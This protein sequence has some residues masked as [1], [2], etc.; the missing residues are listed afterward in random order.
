MSVPHLEEK[1]RR[2]IYLLPNAFTTANL[3]AGFYAVVQAMN[4]RFEVAAI[5]IFVALVLD[6]MDG[7]VARMTNSQSASGEQYDSMADLMSFGIA[8]RSEEHTSELPSR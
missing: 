6:G 5:A 8:P 7:R 4:H 1:R 2:G 3:F